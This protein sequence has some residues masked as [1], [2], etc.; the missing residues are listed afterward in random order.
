VSE[1]LYIHPHSS[2]FAPSHDRLPDFVAYQSI[3][4]SAK[5]TAYMTCVTSID[6]SWLPQLAVGSPL[7]SFGPPLASPPP[8][9]DPARDA[10]VMHCT[11]KYGARGWELRPHA[12]PA[13]EV[14]AEEGKKGR[15]EGREMAC[16]WFARLLL[17]GRVLEDLAPLCKTPDG[18]TCLNDPPALIT[19]RRPVRKVMEVVKPLVDRGGV[20]SLRQL[21]EQ[22]AKDPRFLRA[23]LKMW[24]RPEHQQLF[25]QIWNKVTQPSQAPAAGAAA[26]R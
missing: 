8:A 14:G 10:V 17:E 19:H 24:V 1:P 23:G 16:R 4:R 9:Y 25:Q 11:P 6:P 22:W 20:A 2:L 12:L 13:G 21:R 26:R 18:G 15:E 3:V 7:L 5:G